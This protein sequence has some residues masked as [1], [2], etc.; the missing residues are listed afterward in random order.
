MPKIEMI[1]SSETR[2]DFLGEVINKHLECGIIFQVVRG[3]C[4]I[5]AGNKTLCYPLIP[6]MQGPL[7]QEHRKKTHWLTGSKAI[8][9]VA[10]EDDAVGF[11]EAESLVY[12]QKCVAF[13]RETREY[14][15]INWT[16][17]IVNDRECGTCILKVV[18]R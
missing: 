12:R 14:G 7:L 1:F 16:S 18:F 9:N 11:C 2:L 17:L 8:F 10:L 6:C 4:R 13:G 15:R 3:Q 5:L